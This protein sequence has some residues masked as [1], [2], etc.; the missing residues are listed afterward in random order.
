VFG[1]ETCHVCNDRKTRRRDEQDRPICGD[2]EYDLQVQAEMDAEQRLRCPV[3]GQ[4]ME[5]KLVEGII[6]DQCPGCNAV[7]LEGGEL[8]ELS[9]ILSSSARSSGL[10]TGVAIGMVT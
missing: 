8:D 3:D 7:L 5:K 4:A 6:I 10:A 1:R 9:D 2:C